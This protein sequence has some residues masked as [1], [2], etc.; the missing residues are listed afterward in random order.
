[1]NPSATDYPPEF[2]TLIG[3]VRHHSPTGQEGEA[4]AWLVSNG[5]LLRAQR[6][7]SDRS[8]R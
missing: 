7:T 6:P 2:E 3:L 8:N 1:M 5:I 4:V